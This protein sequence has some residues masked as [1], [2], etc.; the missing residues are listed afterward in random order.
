MLMVL[1]LRIE[2]P[3][4]SCPGIRRSRSTFG[5]WGTKLSGGLWLHR[6]KGSDRWR[7]GGGTTTL[8][9]LHVM[10]CY[11]LLLWPAVD[12]TSTRPL[13]FVGGRSLHSSWNPTHQPRHWSQVIF[14]WETMGNTNQKDWR[15]LY[16][17][18]FP[19]FLLVPEE[20]T[21]RVLTG[22]G[23]DIVFSNYGEFTTKLHNR[24]V[25]KVLQHPWVDTDMELL[26]CQPRWL[27]PGRNHDIQWQS[28][29]SLMAIA[30]NDWPPIRSMC[31][32]HSVHSQLTHSKQNKSDV[33]PM[34]DHWMTSDSSPLR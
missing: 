27:F 30:R 29:Q 17:P 3:S 23:F 18:G 32:R 5:N 20:E 6:R 4:P 12:P 7:D 31:P 10:T 11:D 14:H 28:P 24:N 34:F 2:V 26:I 16:F 15:L 19:R 25:S 33:C 21:A 1:K 22:E 9:N 8:G 13:P